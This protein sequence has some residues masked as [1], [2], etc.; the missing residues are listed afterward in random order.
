MGGAYGRHGRGEKCIQ[1]FDP[2]DLDEDGMIIL[3]WIGS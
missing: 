1:N 3:E 2:K